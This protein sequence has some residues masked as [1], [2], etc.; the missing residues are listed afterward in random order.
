MAVIGLGRFGTAVA[1][2]L[3]RLGHEVLAVD[4][5]GVLV[6]RWADELTHVVQADSTD[7]QALQQLGIGDFDR[8]V[9]AIGTDIEASVLTVLALAEAGVTDIWAKAITRKHGQILERV[10]AHHVV[11]PEFSMGE[12]VAHMLTGSMIDFMEFDDGFSIART[13]A[14]RMTWDKTLAQSSPRT[15]Y[16]VTVVGVKRQGEDFTY[17]RPETMVHRHD[18]LIVSGPTQKVERFCSLQ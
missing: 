17:A 14:P 4:E 1:E 13:L 3:I 15:H 18:Q 5:N 9:V 10:G 11:Y 8:A 7:E 2:A 6:E 16:S 12:R